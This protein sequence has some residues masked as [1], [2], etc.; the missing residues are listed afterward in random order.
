MKFKIAVTCGTTLGHIF[1]ALNISNKL[2]SNN[3]DVQI[4]FI[5]A[6]NQKFL[7]FLSEYNKEFIS[8]KPLCLRKDIFKRLYFFIK[9]FFESFALLKKSSPNLIISFGSYVSFPVVIA[10]KILGI[11]VIIHEQNIIP[12]LANKV[13]F[14]MANSFVV[15]FNETKKFLPVSEKIIYS[16][17]LLRPDLKIYDK[18]EALNRLNQSGC[19]TESKFTILVMGGS[20]GS[21]NINKLFIDALSHLEGQDFQIIHLTG[22][23]DWPWLQGQY[24]KVSF[25]H[26]ITNF[27]KDISLAFS[28]SDL[29]IARSGAM[30]ISELAFFGK[31]SILIPY[32]WAGAHQRENAKVLAGSNACLV[33]EEENLDSRKLAQEISNIKTYHINKNNIDYKPIPKINLEKI[34]DFMENIHKLSLKQ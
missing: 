7:D 25:K 23:N 33:L 11:P 17:V 9:S 15:S 16:G 24:S 5:L 29:V 4:Q 21:R 1:P 30:T 28:V 6:K 3:P 8:I 2:K 31:F 26:Y 12:G 32:P 20:Q 10:A 34:D 13:L 14:N 22:E 27:L 19:L 18:K